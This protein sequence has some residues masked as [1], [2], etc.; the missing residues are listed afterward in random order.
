LGFEFAAMMAAQYGTKT[1]GEV[2]VLCWL[3]RPVSP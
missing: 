3:R 1:C 2:A